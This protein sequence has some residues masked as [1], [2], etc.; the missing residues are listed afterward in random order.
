MHL[1]RQVRKIFWQRCASSAARYG[2][3]APPSWLLH[4]TRQFGLPVS[5]LDSAA[6]AVS[7]LCYRFR[8]LRLDPG[9]RISSPS[10]STST[11][12]SRGRRGRAVDGSIERR[13]F[14]LSNAPSAGTDEVFAA[15]A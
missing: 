12:A 9:V 2:S 10:L 3:P 5:A 8:S 15:A 13:A 6:G 7:C 14:G 1:C 11:A 4:A